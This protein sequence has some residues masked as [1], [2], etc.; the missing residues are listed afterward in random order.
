[1]VISSE[2]GHATLAA[3]CE[4]EERII[5]QLRQRFGHVSAERA[6][7]GMGLENIYEAIAALDGLDTAFRS[8]AEITKRALGSECRMA[9]EAL[10]LFC[11]FLGS[12]AEPGLLAR[13]RLSALRPGPECGAGVQ[14]HLCAGTSAE[15]HGDRAAGRLLLAAG[16]ALVVAIGTEL[17]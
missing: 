17:R 6:V 11:A 5:G 8:A 10:H 4:R 7:S 3:T 2:G 9:H 12:F 1:M 13:R 16:L 15:R 14:C